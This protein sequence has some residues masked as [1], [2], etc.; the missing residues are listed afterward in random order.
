VVGP[1]AHV[2]AVDPDTSDVYFPL[3]SVD[4]HTLLRI[5]RPTP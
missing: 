1:N 2:V 3:M 4:R 5:M